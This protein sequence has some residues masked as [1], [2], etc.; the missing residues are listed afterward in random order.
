[1]YAYDQLVRALFETSPYECLD[2]FFGSGG[3]PRLEQVMM[4]RPLRG[5]G[6]D[7]V[8]HEIVLSWAQRDPTVRFPIVAMGLRP[9]KG[10]EQ[11][12]PPE[13]SDKA[14]SVLA[15]APDR[16]AVLEAFATQFVPGSWSGS[17]AVVIE[18][19]FKK[20][21]RPCHGPCHQRQRPEYRNQTDQSISAGLAIDDLRNN[22]GPHDRI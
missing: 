18:N 13:W 10:N 5:G 19:R 3:P 11:T 6:F 15:A 1:M 2:T 16:V 4:L 17:R 8:P 7:A 20:S 14:L 21:Q 9:L 12:T 22:V